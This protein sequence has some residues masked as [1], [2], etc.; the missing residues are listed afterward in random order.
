M[1]IYQFFFLFLFI[2]FSLLS[3]EQN[4]T[5][6]IYPA[7][8]GVNPAYVDLLKVKK[9]E[10]LEPK[11]KKKRIIKKIVKIQNKKVNPAVSLVDKIVPFS[12]DNTQD[13]LK[14][15]YAK[16]KQKISK[17]AGQTNTFVFNSDTAKKVAIKIWSQDT[18]AN[19][20]INHIK[21]PVDSIKGG[22]F[23]KT[24]IYD[25]PVKGNYNFSISESP[26]N[27]TPY[28]GEYNLELQLLW[29]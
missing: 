16:A 21:G 13:T 5:P 8:K 9:V 22:P 27:K 20:R 4:A 17:K 2:S 12:K 18:L 29:K 3:C 1:K 14:I 6:V 7:K 19:I 25:L 15:A 11:V 24:L 26:M 28:V 23:S 10:E